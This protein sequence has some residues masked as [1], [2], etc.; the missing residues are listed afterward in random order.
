MLLMGHN[1][2]SKNDEHIIFRPTSHSRNRREKS[3]HNYFVNTSR[4]EE[5]TSELQ[6][7]SNLHSF[8]TRRS[9]DLSCLRMYVV[10]IATPLRSMTLEVER[11]NVFGNVTNGTQW[12][13]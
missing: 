2:M 13:E 5:H 10:I 7:Q 1:G 11:T 8:P 6:S 12:D 3:Y 9:S 4:S